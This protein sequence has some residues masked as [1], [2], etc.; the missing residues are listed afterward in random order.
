MSSA[1]ED[2]LTSAH[3]GGRVIRGSVLRVT[4][5]GVGIFAGL[6]TATLLLRHLGVSESGRYVTVL[7]LVAIASSVVD[8]GLNVSASRE[9]ALR[10]PGGRRALMANI[11]GQRL[12][13]TPIAL[14]AIFAFAVLAG[15]PASMR[16][17]AVLAGVGLYVV[18]LADALLLPLTVELR[19]AGL[20]FVDFLKQAVTLACVALLVA[21]GAHLT[22]FFAV[23]IVV[24]LVVLAL[25]PLLAGPGA[26]MRPRWDRSEQRTLLH[27]ALPLAVA[28]VL[29]QV[30]FRLVILLMSLISDPQQTGYFGGSLRA[31]EALV[32]IPILVAGVALPV[33]AAAARDDRARLRYAIEGL[34]EGSVI[35]GV[36]IVLVTVRAAEPV[37]AII[38]GHAF[39]PAGAVLR[40]QVG[41]LLFGALVQIWAVSL[42][43]LGR[44]RDLILT[45]ALGLLG[46]AVLAVALVEPF[47]ALGGA[48]AS[49]LG[50][51]LLAALIYWRL[52]AC[53]VRVT[54]R[55]GFLGRVALAAALAS[56][57]LLMPMPDL[58]AAGLAGALFLG[59]GQLI[60]M[61]PKEVH[62]ALG[63]T[64]LLRRGERSSAR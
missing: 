43:A 33:L 22:A 18:A 60:G 32:G 23:L 59:V 44:Q 54:F 61:V 57:A 53:D 15:Y 19:N 2:V 30:Y 20:A 8:F 14:L 31:M 27:R 42:V 40:I 37:M 41:A 13:I 39:R 29:G 26:F 48:G 5:N 11:L 28:L 16:I 1:V 56:V 46:V 49:V 45:N 64:G 50:D 35:A 7:A 6:A 10:E 12:W 25:I 58:L 62:D 17:G 52:H 55:L 4:G 34:S 3:A 63:S 47:G 9:L 38:G 24:G 51:A 21:L 36:L